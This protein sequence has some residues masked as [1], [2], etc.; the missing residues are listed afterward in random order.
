MCARARACVCDVCIC[1]CALQPWALLINSSGFFFCQIHVNYFLQ[2]V[3]SGRT[4]MF[5]GV[6]SL[7]VVASKLKFLIIP[8]FDCTCV[9]VSCLHLD[10]KR[11]K[12]TKC[13]NPRSRT[14][15]ILR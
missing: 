15:E 9:L 10:R 1:A 13:P 4:Y 14:N 7:T 8:F 3:E 6:Y 5:T 12:N 11:H 2:R